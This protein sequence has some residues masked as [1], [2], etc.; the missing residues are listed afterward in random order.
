MHN[1]NDILEGQMSKKVKVTGLAALLVL[2]VS[3]TASAQLGVRKGLKFGYSSASLTGDNLDDISPLKTMS[4]GVCLEFNLVVFSFE[5]DVLYSTRGA[6]FGE[7]GSMEISY[8]SIPLMLKKKFLPVL[9]HPY[10]MGGLEFNY[11]VS[12]KFDG[13]DIKDTL[14]SQDMCLTVGAGVEFSFLGKG[15]FGELRYSYG[16]NNIYKDSAAPEVKHRVG[17]VMVGILL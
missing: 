12:G 17:H 9:V 16:V 3:T 6:D 2:M 1:G 10:I 13:T 14:N 4:G 15:L 5:G 7:N 8:I 11:L